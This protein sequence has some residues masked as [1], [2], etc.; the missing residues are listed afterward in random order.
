M[1]NDLPDSVTQDHTGEWEPVTAPETRW[2]VRLWYFVTFRQ[3][4][5]RVLCYRAT[6]DD[7]AHY[8]GDFY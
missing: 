7:G 1:K 4:P 2:W 3:V 8:S 6:V 5:P